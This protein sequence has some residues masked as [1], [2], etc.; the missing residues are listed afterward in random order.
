VR[1]ATGGLIALLVALVLN[2]GAEAQPGS[3]VDS[4]YKLVGLLVQQPSPK[5][6]LVTLVDRTTEI[7]EGLASWVL[8]NVGRH[9]SLGNAI[10]IATFSAFEADHYTRRV[11]AARLDTALTRSQRNATGKKVL[12]ELDRCME[13]Q[14]TYVRNAAERALQESF[15]K[16]SSSV[17]HSDIAASLKEAASSLVLPSTAH[18]KVLLIV[19]DMLENSS[20]TSFYE[21][22]TVRKIEPE[23]ELGKIERAGFFAHLGGAK[24]YIVGTAVIPA[25]AQ[26]SALGSYRDPLTIAALKAFWL[27]YFKR[28]NGIVA[29]FGQP[30]LLRD[31]D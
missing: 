21:R 5:R 29:D 30:A 10:A 1:L 26:K 28:S 4:C 22:G 3:N 20:V 23:A 8:R 13:A 16:P 12:R 2:A 6:E 19:S 7:D 27:E 24:I 11:F 25:A 15:G 31:I 17:A 14:L 9:I 18:D